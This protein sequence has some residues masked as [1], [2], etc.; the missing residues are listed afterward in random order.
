MIA[1]IPRSVIGAIGEPAI[2][3]PEL[4]FWG[5]APESGSPWAAAENDGSMKRSSFFLCFAELS[6]AA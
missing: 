1:A 6:A 4:T 5:T 3:V 2:A